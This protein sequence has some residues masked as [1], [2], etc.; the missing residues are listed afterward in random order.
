MKAKTESARMGSLQSQVETARRCRQALAK[1]LDKLCNEIEPASKAHYDNK[2]Q[3]TAKIATLEA[4]LKALGDKLGRAFQIEMLA[5]KTVLTAKRYEAAKNERERK[6]RWCFNALRHKKRWSKKKLGALADPVI[7]AKWHSKNRPKVDHEIF[8]L[9]RLEELWEWLCCIGNQ[10]GLPRVRYRRFERG[11]KEAKIPKYPG[12]GSAPDLYFI[13]AWEMVFPEY[14]PDGLKQ[15]A[16]ERFVR[17]R[18]FTRKVS[19]EADPHPKEGLPGFRE[20]F[21]RYVKKPVKS[22]EEKV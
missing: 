14:V 6:R 22:F 4:E 1:Q 19:G 21:E 12:N 5:V 20:L 15:A 9:C 18:D 16:S 10:F 13:T 8:G 11:I 3:E 17:Y 7:W 2:E